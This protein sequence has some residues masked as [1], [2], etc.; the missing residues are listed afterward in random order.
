[1]IFKK[2][3]DLDPKGKVPE[4]WWAKFTPVGRIKGARIG[5]P[6]QKPLALLKRIIKASSNPADMVLDPFCGC[7]PACI[8]VE[9]EER[10][11]VGIDISPK[12]AD[13]VEHRMV[14]EVGVLYAGIHRT[15]I[16]Q[17]TDLGLV[18]AYNDPR[19]KKRLYGEQGGYCNGRETHFRPRHFEVDHIIPQPKGGTDHISN[20]K[21]LCGPC[22]KMKGTRS[23]EELLVLVT[24][25]GWIKR[26]KAAG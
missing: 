14:K 16:P 26:R 8:A 22:N 2:A 7:A 6:T 4:D 17:R 1:M 10:E 3:F 11:W 19:N 9:M 20:M 12:A 25:K 15:D 13:L 24:D 18:L 23:H 21:L 5:Y